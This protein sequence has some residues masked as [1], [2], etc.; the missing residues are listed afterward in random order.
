MLSKA[1]AIGLL[2]CIVI[3]RIIIARDALLKPLQLS[4]CIFP[5]MHANPIDSK[6]LRKHINIERR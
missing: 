6:E 3:Y 2:M 5:K 4:F 1:L